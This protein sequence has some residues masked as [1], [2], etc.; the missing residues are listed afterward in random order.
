M[1]H[2]EDQTSQLSSLSFSNHACPKFK[3]QSFLKTE[4]RRGK[5][6][7]LCYFI[8]FCQGKINSSCF[9][10]AK[11][12][13]FDFMLEC[14]LKVKKA[15]VPKAICPVSM[16]WDGSNMG[17]YLHSSRLRLASLKLIILSASDWNQWC[18]PVLVVEIVAFCMQSTHSAPELG[19]KVHL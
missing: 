1:K 18:Y 19:L 7:F 17:H 3:D 13:A 9:Y 4:G 6:S 8:V 10:I 2:S 15:I 14:C 11:R 5:G 12:F 16:L